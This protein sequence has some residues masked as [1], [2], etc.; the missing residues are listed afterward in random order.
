VQ[1]APVKSS[2]AVQP[3]SQLGAAIVV[4]S[5]SDTS[6]NFEPWSALLVTEDA[7][8]ILKQIFGDER[9]EK[10]FETLREAFEA[11]F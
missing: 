1:S 8:D 5:D 10:F 3:L 2:L 6:S 11:P 7:K 4:G 9:K